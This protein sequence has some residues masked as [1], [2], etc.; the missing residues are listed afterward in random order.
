M[1]NYFYKLGMKHGE[2]AAKELIKNNCIYV[3]HIEDYL[4]GMS[5]SIHECIAEVNSKEYAEG[6]AD[7]EVY[8]RLT[9]RIVGTE[10]L[11]KVLEN[12]IKNLRALP[13]N[14]Y[15]IGLIKGLEEKN[16]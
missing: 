11:K 2:V 3:D 7:A 4:R 9:T 16:V 14:Q 10:E 8:V 13:K 6:Y 1:T 15:R 5:R 12:R